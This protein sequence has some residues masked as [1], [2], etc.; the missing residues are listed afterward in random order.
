MDIAKLV[1]YESTFKLELVNPVTEEKV[2]ITFEMR[3]VESAASKKVLRK[4]LDEVIERQQ[5]NKLIK[6]ADTIRRELEKVAACIASW[7]WG[8]N[9]YNGVKPELSMKKAVEILE[10]QGWIFAQASEACNKV[11]N[12]TATSATPSAGTLL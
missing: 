10:E 12:F 7:D 1:D 11:A 8:S 3:S 9:T 6:G 4:H 5:R 2:G